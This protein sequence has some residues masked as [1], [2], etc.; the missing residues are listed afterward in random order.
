MSSG[1]NEYLGMLGPRKKGSGNSKGFSKLEP[2]RDLDQLEDIYHA[3]SDSDVIVE[4][5]KRAEQRTAE[6]EEWEEESKPEVEPEIV[7][8]TALAL[9][10]QEVIDDPVRIYLREIGRVSLLSAADEKFL[11]SKMELDRHVG[12]IE[13]DWSAEFGKPALARDVM[14]AVL[15]RL[16]QS[17]PL[18]D[19]VAQE[20]HLPPSVSL[21][22][23][24]SNPEFRA[25]AFRDGLCPGF[26]EELDELLSDE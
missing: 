22:E 5:V 13:K 3:L 25:A 9:G 23:L 1:E 7:L 17:S 19:M 26:W 14:L 21:R 12:K 8:Q 16:C 2:D 10:E 11:A 15:E 18:V 6:L 4:E 24:V 20:L